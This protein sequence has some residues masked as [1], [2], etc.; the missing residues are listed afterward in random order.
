M[1]LEATINIYKKVV[2]VAEKF[3]PIL[4]EAIETVEKYEREPGQ[5]ALL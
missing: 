3:R 2:E 4:A 1:D 5:E